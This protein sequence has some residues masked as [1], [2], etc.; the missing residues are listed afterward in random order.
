VT[1]RSSSLLAVVDRLCEE[2]RETCGLTRLSIVLDRRPIPLTISYE[3]ATHATAPLAPTAYLELEITD[4]GDDPIGYVTLQDSRAAM[5][6]ASARASASAAIAHSAEPLRRA[7]Q[8]DGLHHLP[9]LA[10]TP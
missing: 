4:G 7:L 6:P 2:I 3:D 9:S 8:I 10:Q 1:D 5:Y